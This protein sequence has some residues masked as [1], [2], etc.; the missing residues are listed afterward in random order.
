MYKTVL[1]ACNQEDIQLPIL[2][3]REVKKVSLVLVTGDRGLCGGSENDYWSFNYHICTPRI[4]LK[5]GKYCAYI[6]LS[7]TPLPS[8]VILTLHHHKP[9]S[10]VRFC[11]FKT[12]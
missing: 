10:R 3:V 1:D 8:D 5:P 7:N 11:N 2:D 9:S 12:V 4:E 6:N